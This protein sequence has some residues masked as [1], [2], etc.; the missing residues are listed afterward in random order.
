MYVIVNK[1]NDSIYREPSKKS[2]QTTM[3]KSEAAAKAGITRT[4]KFYEKAIAD[5]EKVVAEGKKEYHSP[6]YNHY[7]DATDKALGR[8]H[9]ADRDNFRVMHV[10]EYA[11]IEPQITRTG[12]CPG[13]GKKMTY[14]SS[15]NEPHYMSPLSESYWSA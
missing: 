6:L 15:I 13:T 11:L 8:T 7:R 4:V 9:V 1:K 3:Y 10:E 2:Y 12:I 5:V 14:T